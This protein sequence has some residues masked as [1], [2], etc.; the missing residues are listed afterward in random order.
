MWNMTSITTE[1][2]Q[3][4]KYA[5]TLTIIW[6]NQNKNFFALCDAEKRNHKV[7]E[8]DQSNVYNAAIITR[9]VIKS[10]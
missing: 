9:T 6:R 3:K 2:K 10:C 7:T 5:E 4:N 1:Q 8:E